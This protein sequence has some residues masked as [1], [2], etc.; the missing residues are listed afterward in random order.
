MRFRKLFGVYDYKFRRDE[1]QQA[2]IRIGSLTFGMW[3]YTSVHHL[4]CTI[5][6][7]VNGQI[8]N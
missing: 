7:T 1:L 3:A 5:N 6:S 4:P 8:F 2:K